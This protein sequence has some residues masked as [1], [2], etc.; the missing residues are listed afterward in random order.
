VE[1]TWLARRGSIQSP[2]HLADFV[3]KEIQAKSGG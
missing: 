1:S 2:E 3:E